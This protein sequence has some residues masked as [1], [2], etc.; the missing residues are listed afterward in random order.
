MQLNHY[1]CNIAVGAKFIEAYKTSH[2]DDEVKVLDLAAN[3]PPHLDYE[4]IIAGYVP[5]ENR[6]ESLKSKYAYRVDNV[7]IFTGAKAIVVSSPMWNWSVPSALKAY[8]DQI[9]LAGVLDAYNKGATGK[10]ITLIL[11]TGGGYT[12]G[13]GY[14]AMDFESGYLSL[15]F[16]RLGATDITVIRSEFTLAGVVP[17]MEGLVEAK[18][19]SRE[20]ANAAAVARANSI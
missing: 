16:T 3:P 20:E 10:P 7:N 17:G 18:E 9:I 5:E 2:P 19:K 8:I 1:L 4:G 12:E 13:S 6:S 14:P 15:V 11:A